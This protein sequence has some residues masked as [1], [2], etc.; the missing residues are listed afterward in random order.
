MSRWQILKKNI[1]ENELFDD[2]VWFAPGE[3]GFTT[4][5]VLSEI[6]ARGADGYGYVGRSTQVSERSEPEVASRT[7]ALAADMTAKAVETGEDVENRSDE[8]NAA[9]RV[10]VLKDMG[11]TEPPATS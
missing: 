2:G 11:L 10:T 4:E 6:K 5:Y 9:A 1:A 3:D 8:I 7:E